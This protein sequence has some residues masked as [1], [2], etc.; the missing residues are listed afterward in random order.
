[1]GV[2]SLSEELKLRRGMMDA[3]EVASLLG[4]NLDVLYR[5]A[6]AGDV[7]H[8]RYLGH[9]KFDPRRLAVWL[10]EREVRSGQPASG[11]TDASK[12]KP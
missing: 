6:K 2:Y 10:E 8:F 5:K 1:M 12:R 3:K 11:K 4:M 9:T 7:P